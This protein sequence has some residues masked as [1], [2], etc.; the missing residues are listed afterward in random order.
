MAA[1]YDRVNYLTSFC[2]SHRFRRQFI[3]KAGLEEGFTV[4]DL[5]CGR[6]ESGALT[7]LL[8]ERAHRDSLIAACI[9]C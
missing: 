5:I 4:V 1:S 7:L 6:G 9:Y 8:R 3:E 2:F